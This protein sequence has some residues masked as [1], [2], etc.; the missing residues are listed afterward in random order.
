MSET[1]TEVNTILLVAN[2][3]MLAIN[4]FVVNRR[5]KESLKSSQRDQRIRILE[6]SGVSIELSGQKNKEEIKITN[7]GELSIDNLSLDVCVM[8]ESGGRLLERKHDSKGSLLK[9]QESVVPLYSILRNAFEEKELIS[10]RENDMGTQ[11][12]PDTGRDVPIIVGVWYAQKDFSLDVAIKASYKVLGETKTQQDTFKLE[13][14]ID[15]EFH[16]E[17]FAFINSDNYKITVQKI[18]G[19]WK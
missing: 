9:A 3:I 6:K 10:Y 16:R 15:P 17:P 12:D 8:T 7:I 13:Y 14:V 4:L 5:A 11:F 19:E 2:A 18:S 1:T